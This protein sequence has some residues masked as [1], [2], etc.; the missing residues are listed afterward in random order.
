VLAFVGDAE[1]KTRIAALIV[2]YESTPK[3]SSEEAAKAA[4]RTRK[5]AAVEPYAEPAPL[6]LD[7]LRVKGKPQPVSE[8]DLQRL[9]TELATKL[10]DGYEEMMR[11]PGPGTL[12]VTVRVQGPATILRGTKAWRERI[13][14]Y[15]FWGNG[16]LLT[17][18][19]AQGA[20]RIADTI[21]GDELVF[22]PTEPDTLLLLPHEDED[23]QLVSKT[24]LLAA[25]TR[26]V[27]SESGKVP[28]TLTYQPTSDTDG[29]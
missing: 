17:K 4:L 19:A 15:W 9:K 27:T 23:V 29:K 18:A 14:Q 10:P 2:R 7:Q 8:A 24:G 13:A 28:G 20:V 11:T 12:R 21:G 25:L 1:L 26:L 5:P 6:Q 22:L 16:P 3:Q